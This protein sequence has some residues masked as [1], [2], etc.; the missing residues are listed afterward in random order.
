MWVMN[1]HHERTKIIYIKVAYE[2]A[3]LLYRQQRK[4]RLPRK[5]MAFSH[6]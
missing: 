4:K 1:S 2:Q 6:N 3:K 5:H